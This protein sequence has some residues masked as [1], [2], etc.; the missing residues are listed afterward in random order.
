MELP[1]VGV[2][3]FASGRE[4]DVFLL[5]EKRVLRRYRWD[6]DVTREAAIMRYVS[7][8]GFP[9]PEVFAAHGSEMV[10]ERLDGPTMAQ[11]VLSGRLPLPDCATILADLHRRLHELP[12][13]PTPPTPPGRP[14]RPTP[15][16][17]PGRPTPPG[18]SGRPARPRRPET[19]DGPEHS[20]QHSIVHLDLHPENVLMTGRGPVVIDWPNAGDGPGDLDT[21]LTA[22]MLAQ[23]AIGSIGSAERTLR[24]SAGDLL[25]RFVAL[26]PGDPTRL[27]DDAVA[28]KAAQRTLSASEVAELGEA[29]ARVLNPISS[30]LD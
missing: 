18:R 4:A 14:G 28:V 29:A 5:D 20:R 24:V 16:G 30:L 7:G 2:E 12:T 27:L 10:M 21:A 11:A 23:V 6:A 9:V 17:R 13:R 19:P 26:A 25:D 15:P 22:L 8:F 3:P 1:G